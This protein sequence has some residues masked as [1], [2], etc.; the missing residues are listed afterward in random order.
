V[1][2]SPEAGDGMFI[3]NAALYLWVH[4]SSQLRAFSPHW[5]LQMLQIKSRPITRH[6]GIW[7]ERRYSSYSFSTSG[8]HECE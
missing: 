6:G 7:G 2:I 1:S 3:R 4:T 8:L 5:E